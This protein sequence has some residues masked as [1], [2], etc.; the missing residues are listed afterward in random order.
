MCAVCAYVLVLSFSLSV[1]SE[2]IAIEKEPFGLS[3]CGS[4]AAHG[5]CFPECPVQQPHAS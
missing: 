5:H 1:P 3:E 2:V 4:E